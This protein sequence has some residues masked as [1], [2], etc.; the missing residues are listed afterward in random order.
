M[1]ITMTASTDLEKHALGDVESVT[2]DDV[3]EFALV[4]VRVKD[5]VNEQ[6][7]QFWLGSHMYLIGRLYHL[8]KRLE[9]EETHPRVE[10]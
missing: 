3:R 6:H 8:L 7:Y 2:L 10:E 5:L 9:F 4:G 1:K